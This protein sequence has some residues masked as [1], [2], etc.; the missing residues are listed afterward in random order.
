VDVGKSTVRVERKNLGLTH[1]KNLLESD[2]ITFYIYSNEYIS[3][4][5]T[6]YQQHKEIIRM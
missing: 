5:E 6:L 2:I 4:P 3:L 1:S